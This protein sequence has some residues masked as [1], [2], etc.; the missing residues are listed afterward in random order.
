MQSYCAI[1]FLPYPPFCL[2]Y[3]IKYHGFLPPP[4]RVSHVKS[5][6]THTMIHIH[7]LAHILDI[8]ALIFN[9]CTQFTMY[10]IRI[11]HA[12]ASH[13]SPGDNHQSTGGRSERTQGQAKIAVW[14]SFSYMCTLGYPLF[15]IFR[16]LSRIR[17]RYSSVAQGH[18]HT[19]HTAL[20]YI[21]YITYIYIYIY[22]YTYII[23]HIY[24]IYYITFHNILHII[25]KDFFFCNK[26]VTL[27]ELPAFCVC[28]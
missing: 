9:S 23:L 19:I 13:Q 21:H 15:P 14:I 18:L 20:H 27:K 10:P 12:T 6:N 25:C 22:I 1:I 17:H 8:C 7:P 2:H 26:L 4:R 3:I 28:S 11:N 24:Y 16:A 5:D